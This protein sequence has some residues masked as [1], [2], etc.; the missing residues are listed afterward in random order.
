M[1][2]HSGREK[3]SAARG[4]QS[5][6]PL[7]G[8]GEAS[9]P[10]QKAY[11]R[12]KWR[13]FFLALVVGLFFARAFCPGDAVGLGEGIHFV[14]LWLLVAAGWFSLRVVHLEVPIVFGK[15]DALLLAATFC[16]VLAGLINLPGGY[17]RAVINSVW[18][19]LGIV[20]G[21][22]LLRQV[23]RPGAEARAT[24]VAG[25]GLAA[26]VAIF[27]LYQ[28]FYEFPQMRAAFSQDPQLLLTQAGIAIQPGSR[29][30]V[31]FRSRV[32]STEPLGTFALANS[33]AG[34]LLA[35]FLAGIGLVVGRLSH[36]AAHNVLGSGKSYKPDERM[37]PSEGPRKVTEGVKS[38]SSCQ[39]E[40]KTPERR[41]LASL[42][43]VL[44]ANG[45]PAL[46]WL[47][48]LALLGT[49]F[50]V[51]LLTK[52][53]SALLG[54]IFGVFI[55]VAFNLYRFVNA[56]CVTRGSSGSAVGNLQAFGGRWLFGVK[57]VLSL[58]FIFGVI[59]GAVVVAGF[60]AG[61][62]RQVL[63]EASK[64]F[65]Y[66]L[67]YWIATLKLVANYPILG[68]GPGNFQIEY[69]RYMLAE[70][71]EVIADPHNFILEIAATA[72][73]PAAC[74]FV[75]SLVILLSGGPWD[76]QGADYGDSDCKG[77]RRG[78]QPQQVLA[79]SRTP[80][81]P[82]KPNGGAGNA[83]AP[84]A[85]TDPVEADIFASTYWRGS[86]HIVLG[87]MGGVFGGY[88]LS[89]VSS[90][91]ASWMLVLAAGST[92]ATAF[93]AWWPWIVGS[94]ATPALSARVAAGG[95]LVHLSASGGITFAGVAGSLWMLIVIAA[96]RYPGKYKGAMTPPMANRQ[97]KPLSRRSMGDLF[98]RVARALFI[99]LRN[100]AQW[101][102]KCGVFRRLGAGSRWI[103]EAIGRQ[104][105]R[106]V[107]RLLPPILLGILAAL[108]YTTAYRP[109]LT[110]RGLLLAAQR[111]GSGNDTLQVRE[112]LLRAAKAD[113]LAPEP[114]LALAQLAWD[115][116]VIAGQAGADQEFERWAQK[117][118]K[119]AGQSARAWETVG[120]LYWD[121][122][123]RTGE[124]GLVGRAA[125]AFRMAAD[126][127]PTNVLIRAK[128]ARALVSLGLTREAREEAKQALILDRKN[129]HSDRKLSQD[130]RAEM[131][132]ISELSPASER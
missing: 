73:I 121:A 102:L 1:K 44:S 127:F 32:Y 78:R 38:A 13:A 104:R 86:S 43:Q 132:A 19:W 114:A 17:M 65:G 51:L 52:S 126:R 82:S 59:V 21:F 56:I 71:S 91:P 128:L 84:G 109:V 16:Y 103:E 76:G 4:A 7:G 48:A 14:L 18:E 5:A 117:F 22:V 26:G 54:A 35:W 29:E 107:V 105:L 28:F 131:I 61:W 36:R 33:L 83:G 75:G 50:W 58:A 92:I 89:L 45:V 98:A 10:E 49:I 118:V 53:R 88:L 115:R 123:Q 85:F 63:T 20:V 31:L 42:A 46:R 27:G 94:H 37:S 62:D 69:P 119:L 93:A 2:H 6:E 34:F 100:K 40:R 70:A 106:P 81:S 72:G 96:A 66:R 95:L 79:A 64:S 80:G 47:G 111:L 57:W 90:V 24:L 30:E 110:S 125:D 124:K 67:Q 8:Q 99:G 122:A 68:C 116:W 97:M 130:F 23:L 129:P 113:P 11:W 15:G 108:C 112:L 39:K 77:N 60:L 120:D 55:L 25:I 101:K 87:A 12:E 3:T 74:L 9:S 41:F